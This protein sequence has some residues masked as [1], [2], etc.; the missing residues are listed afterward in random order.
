MDKK[1]QENKTIKYIK[2]KYVRPMK[3]YNEV[4]LDFELVYFFILNEMGSFVVELCFVE[5][6]HFVIAIC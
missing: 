5:S 6:G 4:R 3:N 2:I 1:F